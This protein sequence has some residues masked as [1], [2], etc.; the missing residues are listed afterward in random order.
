MRAIRSKIIKR[1][2]IK[3]NRLIISSINNTKQTKFIN[4]N[5]MILI[6]F[7]LKCTPTSIEC[8]VDFDYGLSFRAY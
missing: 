1:K 6:I 2:V 4:L 7:K 3:A 5:A 8:S